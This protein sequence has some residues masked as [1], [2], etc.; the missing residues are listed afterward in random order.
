[1]LEKT[2]G[3]PLNC[4]EIKPGNPKG[5]QP[6]IGRTDAEAETPILWPPVARNWLIGKELDAGKDWRQEEKGMTEDELVE[7]HHWLDGWVKQAPG[8]G[9]GQGNLVCFNPWGHKE[10]DTTEWLNW[11]ELNWIICWG[12]HC[13]P[14]CP[15]QAPLS[16]KTGMVVSFY[17]R[18]LHWILNVYLSR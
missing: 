11:T 1:M 15:L 13:M 2:L 14:P 18:G 10:L 9:D 6:W 17:R 12:N 16:D 3:S 8:V 7:W 4:K 5:N